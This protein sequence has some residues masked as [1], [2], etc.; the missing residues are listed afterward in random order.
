[1]EYA[2]EN[3]MSTLENYLDSAKIEKSVEKIRADTVK[4]VTY[5]QEE[6]QAKLD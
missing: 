2:N 1:M 6:L 5:T 4:D 3:G